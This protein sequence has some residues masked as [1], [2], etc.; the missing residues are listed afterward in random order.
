MTKVLEQ[1]ATGSTLERPVEIERPPVEIPPR[2]ELPAPRRPY[3]RWM[4]WML[5]VA[6]IAV[7]GILVAI[8]GD[9]VVL[10]D[11]SF[12]TNEL[13]RMLALAPEID[14]T[15]E[16][17]LF[18]ARIATSGAEAMSLMPRLVASIA[19][20][21]SFEASFPE[22][23]EALE[24]DMFLSMLKANIEKTFSF[25]ASFPTI[26]TSFETNELARMLTLAPTIDTS[27]EANESA[28]M[29]TLAPEVSDGSFEG[30]ELARMMTFVPE[31]SDG[32][33]EANELARML[34]L[35]PEG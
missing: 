1:E 2:P 18:E 24:R 21:S 3:V 27:F 15:L 28:R 11:G 35:G 5:V 10:D 4:G 6:V 33:F 7:A 17:D 29:L 14:A 32:S 13:A 26:D 9:D 34:R 8:Q 19:T 20:T 12:E 31:V 25:E 30:N 23:A 16:A 22:L